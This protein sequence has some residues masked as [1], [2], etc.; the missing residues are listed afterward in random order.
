MDNIFLFF[1]SVIFISISGII[2]PGPLFA[3]TVAKGYEDKKAGAFTALGHGIIEF[4]LIILIYLGV[5]NFFTSNYWKTVAGLAGGI[6]LI[7]M[8]IQIFKKRKNLLLEGKD[9]PYNSLT[10]GAITTVSNPYFFIWWA[11]IGTGLISCAIKFGFIIFILFILVHWLCDFFF[12]LSVSF[13]IFNLKNLG[14][15]KIYEIILIIC[16]LILIFFGIFFIFSILF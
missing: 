7:Y 6:V 2:I 15:K 12:Y 1:S 10:A 11:T 4:P 13:G 9:M 16:S 3:V 14:S 5:I 8:G